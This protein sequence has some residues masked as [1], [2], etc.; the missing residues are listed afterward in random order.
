MKTIFSTS[1]FCPM[2][3]K[4]RI[5]KLK[6]EHKKIRTAVYPKSYINARDRDIKYAEHERL[7]G[8]KVPLNLAGCKTPWSSG[9]GQAPQCYNDF[10]K[11][12]IMLKIAKIE[13]QNAALCQTHYT[14]S[15]FKKGG[16]GGH[17]EI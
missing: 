15:S 5:D 7:K 12:R 4:L 17:V 14:A 3:D 8:S 2:H 10:Q 16:P 11:E 6:Q 9:M 1:I 13:Q